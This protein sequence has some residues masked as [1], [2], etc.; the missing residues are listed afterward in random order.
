MQDDVA[1]S[2]II[3]TRN[4]CH[5]LAACLEHVERLQVP[6]GGAEVIV[7]DNGSTD[8]TAEAVRRFAAAAKC[9]LCLVREPNAGLGRARNAGLARARGHIIAFTDDD[10]YV[11]PD[12]LVQMIKVFEDPCVGYAGGRIL[13]FDPTDDAI[14]TKP[15]EERCLI[16]PH[17]F[18]AEGVIHGANMAIRRQVV[19]AVGGFDER[20]GAGTPFPCEDVEYLARASSAGLAGGY[21][22][23]PVIYHH[24]GRKPGRDAT[25]LRRR[26]DYGRGAYFALFLAKRSTRYLYLKHWCWSIRTHVRKGRFAMLW[27]ELRGALHFALMSGYHA[28]TSIAP[29]PLRNV[30]LVTTAPRLPSAFNGR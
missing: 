12:F 1:I 6:P 20:L 16:P 18:L 2:L 9:Q 15:D 21:F 26:Y 23:G 24:H 4:R 10:C 30:T 17:S 22:P 13:R 19:N 25:A 29:S 8:G 5:A 28:F 7:V 27:R 14:T 3:C 11:C